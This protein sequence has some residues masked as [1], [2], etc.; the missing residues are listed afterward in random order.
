MK[1]TKRQLRRIIK[2]ERAKLNEAPAYRMKE[3][4]RKKNQ[5]LQQ[6]MNS[7]RSQITFIEGQLLMGSFDYEDMFDWDFGHIAGLAD[8]IDAARE[9]A[10]EEGVPFVEPD[11]SGIADY[12]HRGRPAVVSRWS[13]NESRALLEYEQYVDEDGNVYDDEG[14]VSRRGKEFGRRYGGGTYGLHGLPRGGGYT[15]RRKTSYVGQSANAELIAAVEAVLDIKPNNFLK[16]ILDQLKKG[17]GLSTKQKSIVH[18]IVSKFDADAAKLFEARLVE[19]SDYPS[20][21]D[22]QDYMDDI[23]DMLEVVVNKYAADGAFLDQEKAAGVLRA[24]PLKR[25]LNDLLRLALDV[26]RNVGAAESQSSSKRGG[27]E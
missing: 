25:A 1:I 19:Y 27:F 24:G 14:N 22:L 13:M 9:K 5:S 16:S 26:E 11:T 15:P 7:I 18:K 6:L 8:T 2:E 4:E 21:A 23:A 12:Q 3:Y 20:Y 17:R 10:A